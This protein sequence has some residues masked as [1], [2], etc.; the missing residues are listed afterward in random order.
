MTPLC[1]VHHVSLIAAWAADNLT[2]KTMREG[3]RWFI[4]QAFEKLSVQGTK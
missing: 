1:E 3:Y 2:E 4:T